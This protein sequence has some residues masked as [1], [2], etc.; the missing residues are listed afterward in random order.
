MRIGRQAR[1][2]ACQ[3]RYLRITGLSPFPDYLGGCGFADFSVPPS[4]VL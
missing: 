2:V 4:P 3:R 1:G